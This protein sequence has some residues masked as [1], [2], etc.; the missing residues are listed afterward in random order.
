M[1]QQIENFL[2]LN[3]EVLFKATYNINNVNQTGP[4][5]IT[6][7]LTVEKNFGGYDLLVDN[8]YNTQ[9]SLIPPTNFLLETITI[10]SFI[11]K[12][13]FVKNGQIQF[14]SFYQNDSPPGSGV[15]KELFVLYSV[16]SVDGIY[17]GVTKVL[18]NAIFDQR[19]LYFIGK[20]R[21]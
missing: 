18:L 15:T 6:L 3:E 19:V 16:N 8:F 7:E 1:A 4:S 10:S 12:N 13:E 2:E 5:I 11:G 17:N 9:N 20:K 14:T 21:C